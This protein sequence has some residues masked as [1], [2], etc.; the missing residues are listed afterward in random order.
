[1]RQWLDAR[2]LLVVLFF[3]A[4]D[5]VTSILVPLYLDTSG[6]AVSMV[7]YS[8]GCMGLRACCHVSPVDSSIRRTEA[9]G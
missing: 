6:L 7:A 5:G 8:W 4:G 3:Q 1:M 2:P 9:G